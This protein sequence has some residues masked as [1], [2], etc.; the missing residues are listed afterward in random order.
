M[1]VGAEKMQHQHIQAYKVANRLKKVLSENSFL[2]YP[3]EK[4]IFDTQ[5]DR[6]HVISI[7]SP[8]FTM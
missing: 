3:K 5:E 4:I 2:Q 8:S 1:S 7:P 6:N